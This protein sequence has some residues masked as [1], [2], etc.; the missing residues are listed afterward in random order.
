MDTANLYNLG[1]LALIAGVF[2]FGIGLCALLESVNRVRLWRKELKERLDELDYWNCQRC[3]RCTGC[4]RPFFHYRGA[5]S[6]G[7]H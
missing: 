3:R 2:V 5:Q 6:G 7:W 4:G 1:T